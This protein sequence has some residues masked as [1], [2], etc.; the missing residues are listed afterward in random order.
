MNG[1]SALSSYGR[2]RF[3]GH[4]HHMAAMEI[5]IDIGNADAVDEQRALAADELD[6]VT[7]ERLEVSDQTALG[8][9]HQFVDLV[10]GSL[11]AE[12]EPAVARR[13]HR[14]RTAGPWRRP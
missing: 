13:T 7:G 10:V 14:R 5:D 9:V 11:G 1:L 4:D 8:L 6:G 3:L 12:G 2:V